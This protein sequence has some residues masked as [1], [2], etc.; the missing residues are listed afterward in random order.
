[1]D[2]KTAGQRDVRREL[3]PQAIGV[4]QR[5]KRSFGPNWGAFL[6]AAFGEPLGRAEI[7]AETNAWLR[8][9]GLQG[10]VGV[11]FVADLSASARVLV[12]RQGLGV[13]LELWDCY[14]ADGA[15][16]SG[17]GAI[18]KGAE[19]W[20]ATHRRIG[21]R[22]LLA[23]EVGTHV[24]R[25][26]NDATLPWS[27]GTRG[28]WGLPPLGSREAMAAEEGLASLVSAISA[29]VPML[30][31]PA[32]LYVAAV[33]AAAGSAAD[34][35]TALRE[36]VSDP[37]ARARLVAR[38]KRGVP[39]P[40]SP[41]ADGMIQAY[42][43]GACALLRALEGGRCP[44]PS[45]LFLGRVT[46][47]SL[48]DPRVVAALAAGR[49]SL[50]PFV[51]DGAAL[52]ASFLRVGLASGLLSR[53]P[54][55]LRLHAPRRSPSAELLLLPGV[56]PGSRRRQH[57][58]EGPRRQRW[59]AQAATGRARPLATAT[60]RTRHPSISPVRAGARRAGAATAATSAPPA[61][62]PGTDPAKA[63]KV[64]GLLLDTRAAGL[65]SRPAAGTGPRGST[66][67][68]VRPQPGRLQFPVHEANVRPECHAPC[69]SRAVSRPL[70]LRLPAVGAGRPRGAAGRNGMRAI[71]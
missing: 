50:P 3:L 16:G 39:D 58:R 47:A 57:G 49:G 41:G 30:V 27:A 36:W 55:R 44:D 62:A 21:V 54:P 1:M 42:F 45:A 61:R 66:R 2:H 9:A 14:G 69:D 59:R 28:D 26:A 8:R 11:A 48:S 19:C 67:D 15:A 35:D 37:G 24:L 43:E 13:R 23:H 4:C 40:S 60:A 25:A 29:R 31:G 63:V 5:L 56:T 7:L 53:G 38:A 70:T 18:S 33:E 22:S 10:L 64:G 17:G 51:R 52:R 46:L 34:T 65:R 71:Q 20:P 12:G 32:L 6:A 68:A